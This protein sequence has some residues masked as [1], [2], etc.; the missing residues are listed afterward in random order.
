MAIRIVNGRLYLAQYDLSGDL[1]AIALEATGE[2]QEVTR[3]TDAGRRRLAGLKQVQL[4]A[5]GYWQAGIGLV[6]EALFTNLGVADVPLSVAVKDGVAGDNAYLFRAAI[7]T[8]EMGAAL[9]EV[10]PF[11]AAAE[12]SAGEVLA[13]GLVLH[14]ATQTATGVGTAFNLGSVASG[15]TLY[16]A[17]HVLTVSGTTPS[18]TA[19]LESDDASGFL[20]PTTR[21]TFAAKTAAGSEWKTLAGPITDAWWRVGFT[22]SGTAPSF[23]FI[24]TAGIL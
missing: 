23:K 9:G 21:L 20:S 19:R 12:G 1:N 16:A 10:S 3:L 4:E 15:Q 11:R 5:R 6:D 17:L 22:I 2:L 7:G 8:Y 13:R 14:N 24:V 18:L